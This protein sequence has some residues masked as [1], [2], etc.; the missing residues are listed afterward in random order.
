MLT[1]PQL[2]NSLDEVQ[3]DVFQHLLDFG[4]SVSPRGIR[5]LESTAISFTLTNPRSRCISTPA[6]RWSLPL[7]LGELCWHLAGST[8]ASDLAYYSS[9]WGSLADNDGRI[10]G[11]CYGSKIFSNSGQ[12]SP[13]TLVKDLLVKDPDSRRAVIYFADVR[14]HLNPDCLDASCTTSLQFLIRDGRL[15]AV[16]CMRSNDAVWGLP[17]DV[18][19]FTFLQEMMVLELN[20]PLGAYH[21]F[22]GSLHLYERHW[23]LARSVAAVDWQSEQGVMPVLEDLGQLDDF[24]AIEKALRRGDVDVDVNTLSPYWRDLAL[25]LDLYKS[26]RRVGWERVLVDGSG[27][28]HVLRKKVPVP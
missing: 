13:W 21:H 4:I 28:R 19:L 22:A 12:V 15:D 2:Y 9:F 18:F 27:L 16:S 11:S 24:L 5:T 23:T 1:T 20:V 26:S 10:T 7:A 6:R 14:S 25:V 3:R 17:Y 8:S